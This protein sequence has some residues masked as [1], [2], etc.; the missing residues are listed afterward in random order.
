LNRC[1]A[2][3]RALRLEAAAG[4]FFQTANQK[5]FTSAAERAGFYSRWFGRYA[6]IFPDAFLFGITAEDKVAAYVAGCI[7][8][9]SEEAKPL[10]ADIAYFTPAFCAALAEYPSHFHINVKPEM[11]G[12]GLGRRLCQAFIGLCAARG[13]QGV[14]VLTGATSPAVRF[15]EVCGFARFR[16]PPALG[17]GHTVLVE[18]I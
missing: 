12:R 10:I 13:S 17:T 4:I 2:A 7:A 11:Q 16:L 5:T 9:F 14:H 1:S 18:R 3:E 15:Y 6:E 8:S